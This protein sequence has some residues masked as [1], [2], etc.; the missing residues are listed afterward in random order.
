MVEGVLDMKAD[1]GTGGNY[2]HTELLMS[3][4]NLLCHH[5]GVLRPKNNVNSLV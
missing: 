5:I 2:V 4:L 3:E 1:S